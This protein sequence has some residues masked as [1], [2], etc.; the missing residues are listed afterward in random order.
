ML[1]EEVL[2]SLKCVYVMPGIMVSVELLSINPENEDYAS[3][4]DDDF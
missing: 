4:N 1:S 2:K 3:N